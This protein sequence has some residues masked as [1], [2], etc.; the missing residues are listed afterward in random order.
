M[1]GETIHITSQYLMNE[2][3]PVVATS[4][5]EALEAETTGL[6]RDLKTAMDVNNTSKEKIQALTSFTTYFSFFFFLFLGALHVL[7][8][9]NTL[10]SLDA[11]HVLGLLNNL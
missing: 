4:K 11:L 3:K 2:E 8:L 9:L 10:H 1:L 7:G 5:A 6:R